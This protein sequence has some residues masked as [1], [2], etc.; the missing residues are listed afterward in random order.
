MAGFSEK[1]KLQV[2]R[3]FSGIYREK[4]FGGEQSTEQKLLGRLLSGNNL[5]F[6]DVG[7]NRGEFIN[8]AIKHL[9][10]ER[11]WA[12]EPLP[13]FAQKLRALFK[14]IQVVNAALSDRP[15]KTSLFLPVIN[16]VPDDSLSSVIQPSNTNYQTF[17]TELTTLD[18]LSQKNNLEGPAFLKIDVEGH[19]FEVLAGGT[20]FIT[21]SARIML[22]EIEERHHAG[23]Q[24]PEM[25]GQVEQMGFRAF[26]YHPLKK[27]LVA[28]AEFPEVMQDQATLNTAHY[29][30]NFWFLS[31][32]INPESV[33]AALNQIL[34]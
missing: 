30:N 7:A 28:F 34:L 10:G 15:G 18:L 31:K 33:I 1:I 12:I 26:Y 11:I 22:I 25:I 19:E 6:I 21:R 24:L 3:L 23:R 14:T 5:L 4:L 20:A 9:A 8:T 29:V 16:G 13:Y 32:Q 2:F 27:Q 17:E